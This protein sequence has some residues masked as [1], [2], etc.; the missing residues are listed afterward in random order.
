ME[1]SGKPAASVA[2]AGGVVGAG[3]VDGMHAATGGE[4]RTLR[5]GS[6]ADGTG[7]AAVLRDRGDAGGLRARRAGGEPHGAADEDRRQPRSS[8]QSRFDGL[9]RA[10]GDAY[11]LRSGPLAGGRQRGTYLELGEFLGGD[12][13][14]A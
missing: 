14:A 7:Q 11:F 9:D 2:A 1:R 6:R 12:G 10:G 5:A 3:G 13:F 8:G 4:D